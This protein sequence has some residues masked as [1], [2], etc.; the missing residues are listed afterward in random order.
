MA[1]AAPALRAEPQTLFHRIVAA[2]S[3]LCGI[4]AALLIVGAVAITCQM[5]WLRFVMNESTIWQTE[6][7]TYMMIA[8]TMLGLPYVQLLRGHV[9]VDLLP[10]M[11][12]PKLRL[13]LAESLDG[14]T[15]LYKDLQLDSTETV[16][17]ALGV[18]RK[19]GVSVKLES[20]Q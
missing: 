17:V 3:T 1:T 6:A 16:E 2:L 13:G 5:I 11:L 4:V 15:L 12:P 20:R 19:L 14:D 8:A 10:R 9:N 7:V 18:K